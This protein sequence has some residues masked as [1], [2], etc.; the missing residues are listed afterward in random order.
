MQSAFT[1]KRRLCR[2]HL[3][4]PQ[5]IESLHPSRFILS[6]KVTQLSLPYCTKSHPLPTRTVGS[7]AQMRAN[8]L[9][10]LAIREAI[11]NGTENSTSAT[12]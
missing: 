7:V 11:F 1:L 4:P 8:G 9:G 10:S 12:T 6:K 3:N 5:T 2:R